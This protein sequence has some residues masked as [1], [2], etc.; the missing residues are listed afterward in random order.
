MRIIELSS[1]TKRYGRNRGITDIDLTVEEGEIFGYLGPNGAGKTTTIR[2]MLDLIRPTDGHVRI[3]GLDP[4]ELSARARIG[5]LPGELD[6]Y[7]NL[8]GEELL[9]YM[10]NL[11]GNGHMPQAHEYAERLDLDLG[12]PIAELSKGNK[13]KVGLVQALMHRP[14]LLILDE[15]TSGLDPL[16]QQEVYR[17]IEEAREGGA[18]VFLSSHILSEVE[19]IAE[20][21]GIIREGVLVEVAP[22]AVLRERAVRRFEITFGSAVSADDFTSVEGIGAVSVDGRVLTCTVT[23]SV[24]GLIKAIARHQVTN[25][26]S[27][28]ADLEGLFLAYY[29]GE[30]DAA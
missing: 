14:E 28:G 13:Q 15:P 30:D 22:L 18:T 16:V 8:T 10:D 17:M 29:R 25:V 5:Y 24:D 23:G 3:F 26:L 21:V 6:L 20:R 19:R 7:Q 2:L 9:I 11:R 1:V 27:H 12:R 4:S